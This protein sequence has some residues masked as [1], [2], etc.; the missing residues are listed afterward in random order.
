MLGGTER[1]EG[2]PFFWTYHYGKRFE[3]LGHATE[4]DDV[5]V[6]GNLDQHRFIALQVKQGRVVGVLGCQRERVMAR[7]AER[8]RAPIQ[9]EQALELV[10]RG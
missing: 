10:R 8:L 5:I 4:W 9:A 7:F 6:D 1:Y 2:V 3:C